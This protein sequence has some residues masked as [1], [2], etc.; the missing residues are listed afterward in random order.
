MIKK[1]S[2]YKIEKE[3]ILLVLLIK[4]K[5]LN[6]QCFEMGPDKVGKIDNSLTHKNI[7]KT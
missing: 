5:S 1:H 6:V 2:E 7:Y 4:Y 3:K